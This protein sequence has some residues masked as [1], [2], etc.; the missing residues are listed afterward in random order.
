MLFRW[1]TPLP[2][3]V[4]RACVKSMAGIQLSLLLSDFRPDREPDDQ[5]QLKF[6]NEWDGAFVVNESCEVLAVTVLENIEYNASNDMR[7]SSNGKKTIRF[8]HKCKVTPLQLVIDSY[9]KPQLVD[10]GKYVSFLKVNSYFRMVAVK[11]Y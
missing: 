7:R 4:L 1:P 10:T 3:E 5:E 6:I 2:T 8:T 11:I 9:C